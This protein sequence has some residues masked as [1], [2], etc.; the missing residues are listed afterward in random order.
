[1]ARYPGTQPGGPTYYPGLGIPN[2]GPRIWPGG[3]GP[4]PGV[5]LVSAAKFNSGQAQAYIRV[6]TNN[7]GQAQA[8][9]K[10]IYNSFAQA[11]AN[12]NSFGVQQ[13]GQAQGDIKATLNQHGQSQADVKTTLNQFGQ[14]QSDIK[15]TYQSY[16]Q[17]QALIIAT[18]QQYGQSQAD[19]KATSNNFGQ[20]QADIKATSNQHGQ[21]QG[22]IKFTVGSGQAQGYILSQPVVSEPTFA[23]LG[24][25]ISDPYT[26]VG[27]FAYRNTHTFLRLKNSYWTGGNGPTL[28][29]TLSDVEFP[30]GSGQAK[31]LIKTTNNIFAQTQA[32]IHTPFA[33]AQAQ[34]RIVG[35]STQSGQAV[36]MIFAIVLQD[37][38]TRVTSAGDIN[39]PEIGPDY[40]MFPAV[41]PNV[42]ID[43]SRFVL[44]GTAE[45]LF[46]IYVPRVLPD[47][48]IS[49]IEFTAVDYANFEILIGQNNGGSSFADIYD[50]G[51]LSFVLDLVGVSLSDSTPIVLVNGQS[52]AVK[53]SVIGT[54]TR[55]K[56]WQIGTDEPS[57]WTLTVAD[58]FSSGEFIVFINP[59]TGFVYLDNYII[60]SRQENINAKFIWGQ[61]QGQIKFVIPAVAQAQAFLRHNAGYGQAL[62]DIKAVAS[63]WGQA[64]ALINRAYQAGQARAYI[65]GSKHAQAQALIKRIVQ[66]YAQANALITPTFRQYGQ[67]QA[68]IFGVES[69]RVGQ[70]TALISSSIKVQSGNS[71][72]VLFQSIF[73]DTFTRTTV[74]GDLGSPDIG[75]YDLALSEFSDPSI[76][77]VNGSQLEVNFS[78]TFADIF[79]FTDVYAKDVESSIEFTRDIVAPDQFME[80]SVRSSLTDE[81]AVSL[82]NGIVDLVDYHSGTYSFFDLGVFV[83]S[84]GVT[85]VVKLRVI[86][87]VAKVKIWDKAGSE[88]D[89]QSTTTIINNSWGASYYYFDNAST[90][91]QLLVDNYNFDTTSPRLNIA[92]AQAKIVIVPIFVQTNGQAQARITGKP[93]QSGQAMAKIL[94]Y[95]N[96]P[97]GQ[98]QA[99]IRGKVYKFGQAQGYIRPNVKIGQAQAKIK[100]ISPQFGQA[101]AYIDNQK[102]V[103]Q[104]QAYIAGGRYLV[105]Y[106]GYPLPGY[107]QRESIESVAEI[108]QHAVAYEDMSLSEHYG[109]KNKLISLTMLVWERDYYQSKEKIKEA[110]TILRARRAGFSPLYIQQ[111]DRHYDALA[112]K[113]SMESDA[114]S[115][116]RIVNY[117]IEFEAKPW[118][119]SDNTITLSG[120]V[121]VDTDQV[122]RDIYDGGWTPVSLLVTGTNVTVSGYTATENFTGYITISGSVVDQ[123]VTEDSYESLVNNALYVGPGKTTFVIT[124]ATSCTITY[125]NRWYL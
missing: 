31:A 106:N 23:R 24:L 98:A 49:Y 27:V 28:G 86:G 51:G 26:G 21:A 48:F 121:T 17:S 57:A 14:A 78:T 71:Q 104:A 109:L 32:L 19:I 13:Y 55:V 119:I 124:G 37:T 114:R 108:I 99:Y 20:A 58:A 6:T 56:L 101:A 115:S 47:D 3:Q 105:N 91:H 113:I 112:I 12:I 15:T 69:Y 50:S 92:Q 9:I 68:Q 79:P 60:V 74:A 59:G 95:N 123:V 75:T 110:A 125:H 10:Q 65:D 16:A 2:L 53:L 45:D 70:A 96:R 111:T 89:W 39:S 33:Q 67:A 22:Y 66:Q 62:A 120:A 122:S 4:N 63:K 81:V 1:M 85:Y 90:A 77:N 8:D 43:G 40:L 52:Y 80:L 116:G 72:G 61:A 54:V 82:H 103:A 97:T 35:R 11:Q 76:F 118:L 46:Q 100:K 102:K 29:L 42:S 88:P 36:A 44:D 18:N 83:I 107:A 73:K 64:Q 38:F 87:T 7:F 84:A 5:P 117:D 34:A 94:D 93:T 30:H 25:N 41:T